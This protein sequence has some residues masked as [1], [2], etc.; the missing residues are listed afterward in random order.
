MLFFNYLLDRGKEVSLKEMD[1]LIKRM[2]MITK[3]FLIYYNLSL[4]QPQE[5]SVNFSLFKKINILLL[6]FYIFLSASKMNN[7]K[8]NQK[9]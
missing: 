6:S 4:E 9:R 3:G 8:Q 2:L 5:D 1:S 7:S